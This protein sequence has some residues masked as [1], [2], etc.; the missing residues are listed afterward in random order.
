MAYLKWLN[1]HFVS[2]E[3]LA[4]EPLVKQKTYTIHVHETGS[5]V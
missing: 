4:L 1:L 3:V 5:I 2:I